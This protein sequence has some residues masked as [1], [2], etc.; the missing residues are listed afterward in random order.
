MTSKFMLAAILGAAAASVSPGA[1]AQQPPAMGWYVGGEVGDAEIGSTSDTSFKIL[2]GYQ[3]N[4]NFAVEAGYSNLI[5]KGNV[6]V[7]A[8]ELTGV[9]ILPLANRFSLFGKLGLAKVEVDVGPA[10]SDKTEFTYGFGGQYD[11]TQRLAFR[12]Q[13]Q[14][15]DTDPEHVDLISVGVVVRF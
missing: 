9:G 8:L 10:S 15:Y 13:W 11:F 2:G 4:R 5:D 1:L 3:I 14:R 6:E 12:L 7:T